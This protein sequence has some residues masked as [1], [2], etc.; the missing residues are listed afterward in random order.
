MV[1]IF[2][3]LWPMAHLN[4]QETFSHRPVIIIERKFSAWNEREQSSAAVYGR[5]HAIN[6]TIIGGG[7]R[8][9]SVQ[10]S[11]SYVSSARGCL[12]LKS[13]AE[14]NV[15]VIRIET[16]FRF[17]AWKISTNSFVITY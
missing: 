8:A 11:A 9:S 6:S 16:C 17:I 12:M 15:C 5:V 14:D 2:E 3:A 1:S 13:E 10:P 4:F 7:G